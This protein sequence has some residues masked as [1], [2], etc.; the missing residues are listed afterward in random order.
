[1]EE[2][3]VVKLWSLN[4]PVFPETGEP[5]TWL[6]SR[7]TQRGPEERIL[8]FPSR[9]SLGVLSATYWG[10]RLP[11]P[12]DPG[13]WKLGSARGKVT[14]PAGNQIWLSVGSRAASDLSP[15]AQLGP[16]DLQV[17]S[18]EQTS[19]EDEQLAYLA[20]LTG[21]RDLSLCWTGITD[22][23]LAHLDSLRELRRLDLSDT[24]VTDEGLEHIAKLRELRKLNLSYTNVQGPG[25]AHLESLPHLETLNLSQTGVSDST[26][27]YL[28]RLTRL[29]NL[30]LEL[31]D[32]TDEGLE[33]LVPLTGLRLLC[34]DH[35]DDQISDTGMVQ[36]ARLHDLRRLHLLMTDVTD[37]GLARLHSL[38][39]LEFVEL[40]M[41]A[42]T[43]SGI[44]AV[45]QALP[46]CRTCSEYDYGRDDSVDES[47]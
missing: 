3:P 20:G 47:E 25:L 17:V 31:T 14:V 45:K 11:G 40:C 15:L 9:R 27:V 36:V 1:M 19:V 39:R 41:T 44:A 30:Y 21:L 37:V 16:N 33:H 7:G 23:C 29:R 12:F 10:R 5:R 13:W 32:I 28:S 38:K 35:M 34:L 18:L 42:V 6:S 4:K 43:R 8:R 26:A 24:E 22:K 46:K 2:P